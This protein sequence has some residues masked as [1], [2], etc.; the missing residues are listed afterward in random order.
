MKI[1]YIY[2][3]LIFQGGTMKINLAAYPEMLMVD[4]T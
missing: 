3:G 1:I 2:T 4:A